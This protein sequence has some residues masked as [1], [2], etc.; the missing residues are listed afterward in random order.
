MFST[1]GTEWTLAVW[2]RVPEARRESTR[3]TDQEKIQ[4]TWKAVHV[5]A[6]GVPPIPDEVLKRESCS[7]SIT[8]NHVSWEF[9]PKSPNAQLQFNGVFH[10]DPTKQPKSVDF[11]YLGSKQA[12]S[13]LGI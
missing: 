6:E 9:Y 3:Q 10:L 13:M 5:E 1:Q 11:F 2:Q 12:K 7:L 8:D 4:G